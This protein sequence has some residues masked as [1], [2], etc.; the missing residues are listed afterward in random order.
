MKLFSPAVLTCLLATSFAQAEVPDFVLAQYDKWREEVGVRPLR[1]S[2]PRHVTAR[3]FTGPLNRGNCAALAAELDSPT[4]SLLVVVRNNPRQADDLV[5]NWTRC[6]TAGRHSPIGP[7]PV[8]YENCRTAL[9]IAAWL[10][11]YR[12]AIT[13]GNA[14]DLSN[15]ANDCMRRWLRANRRR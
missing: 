10:D 1:R 3:P 2:M 12:V 7:M 8:T 14:R 6:M 13:R 11:R 4:S 9:Q 15:N 5:R